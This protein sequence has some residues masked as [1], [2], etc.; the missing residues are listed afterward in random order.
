VD[1]LLHSILASTGA[2][3]TDHPGR[4]NREVFAEDL[5]ARCGL[6]LDE[7]WPI[8]EGF[9]LGVF[10]S[11]RGGAGPSEGA[12]EAVD[13]AL[14]AGFRVAVATQPIFPRI[15]IRQRLAWAELADIPF[16][17]LTTYETMEACKPLPRYFEQTARSIGCDPRACLMVGDDALLDMPASK[18][19]MR[20]FFTGDGP[21]IADARGGLT[22]LAKLIRQ[23]GTDLISR[24][25]PDGAG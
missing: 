12:R 11:L 13:A 22:D 10:P 16:D 21:A 25:A 7:A 20:T 19:G 6:V 5:R 17:M 18:T 3:Q 15:A 2:M 1:D 14:S 9:Y 23:H 4:T 8:F 24:L